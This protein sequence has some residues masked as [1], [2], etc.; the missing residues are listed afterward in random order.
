[1]RALRMTKTGINFLLRPVK[2]SDE[3]LLKD[4]FYSLSDTSMYNRFISDA[5]ICLRNAAGLFCGD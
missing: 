5:C 2:I 1:M 3:P 4:F